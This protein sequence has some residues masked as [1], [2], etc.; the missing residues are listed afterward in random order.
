MGVAETDHSSNDLYWGEAFTSEFAVDYLI[1][2]KMASRK[3]KI[4]WGGLQGAYEGAVLPTEAGAIGD[5]KE[6]SNLRPPDIL[7]KPM[8]L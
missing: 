5:L 4:K 6:T 1:S 3:Q 8:A 2:I 7:A